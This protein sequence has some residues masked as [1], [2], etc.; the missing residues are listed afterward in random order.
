MRPHIRG[1]CGRYSL[2]RDLHPA[3]NPGD[4]LAEPVDGEAFVAP[5]PGDGWDPRRR[6]EL[7]ESVELAF[8]AA[9]QHLPGTQRAVLIRREV[10][11][12]SAAEVAD[13][14]DTSV[15]SVN[16]ALAGA[17]AAG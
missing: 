10:L 1:A 9:V 16:S 8:V 14:L 11:A 4:A 13:A 2:P 5:Y 3:A 6:F 12:F 17:A 7:R 15:A